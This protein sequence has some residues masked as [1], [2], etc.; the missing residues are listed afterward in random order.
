MKKL[1][2]KYKNGNLITELYS[3]GTRIR[4]TDDDEFHPA[5]A[6]NVDVQVSNRCN[7]GCPM[8]Y[9][10]CTPDGAFGKLDGWRFL[11]S[12]HPG[13][14]MAVNLNF[15]MADNFMDFLRTVKSKGV[16]PNV[17]I[18]QDHFMQHEDIIKQ[19]YDEELIYGLGVSLTEPTPEFIE[20]IK[21]YPNAVIH[22]ING[23]F[24]IDQFYTLQENDLKLLIL[25]Y[26]D[27]G[28][29]VQYKQT[30]SRDI[31]RNQ[32]WL[33]DCLPLVALRFKVV[34]FDNLAIEQLN[35]GRLLTKKQWDKFYSGND[36]SFTFFINLVDGY[37]AK[38]SLSEIHYEI[39]DKTM[40]E[41]FEVIRNEYD[42][43]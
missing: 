1:L 18:N 13:T 36:G 4:T 11:D 25:G 19:L 7:H 2:A 17:T 37:F 32:E 10:N 26:K 39:G 23:I 29:G 33:H 31:Q 35:V 12:L 40:D 38:N 5:F 3:D 21:K 14:E 27:I 41:M 42:K 34:S 24:N 9:A 22:V 28:R 6:E 8:C 30:D 16:F 43:T 15:P 20:R